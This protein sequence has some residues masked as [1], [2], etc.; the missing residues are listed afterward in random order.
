MLTDKLI[1]QII[2]WQKEAQKECM[3]VISALLQATV[4]FYS[5]KPLED[6]KPAMLHEGAI[7][8]LTEWQK[9]LDI[10][11]YFQQNFSVSESVIADVNKIAYRGEFYQNRAFLFEACTHPSLR[12][13]SP[14]MRQRIHAIELIV[15]HEKTAEALYKLNQVRAT[16]LN[17]SLLKVIFSNLTSRLLSQK[18]ALDSNSD[19]SCNIDLLTAEAVSISFQQGWLRQQWFELVV[20]FDGNIPKSHNLLHSLKRDRNYIDQRVADHQKQRSKASEELIKILNASACKP[21]AVSSK[22]G[23]ASFL[24]QTSPMWNESPQTCRNEIRV[25]KIDKLFL[26]LEQLIINKPKQ[27]INDLELVLKTHESELAY[28]VRAQIDLVEASIELMRPTLNRFRRLNTSAENFKSKLQ[29]AIDKSPHRF[30]DDVLYRNMIG[31]YGSLITLC[32]ELNENL[33]LLQSRTESFNAVASCYSTDDQDI[34]LLV[35]SKLVRCSEQ[36][37]EVSATLSLLS[38][39]AQLRELHS[40]KRSLFY[41]LSGKYHQVDHESTKNTKRVFEEGSNALQRSSHVMRKVENTVADA[42]L[43][44]IKRIKKSDLD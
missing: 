8:L 40:Q 13:I 18:E 14:Q 29:L 35:C 31:S 24:K 28:C 2:N 21:I 7:I 11:F 9:I 33:T 42:Q 5:D 44:E 17:E 38:E 32:D 34:Y 20:L 4:C 26:P 1:Q 41:K 43:R 10:A 16:R 15:C 36:L 23:E 37:S 30:C 25:S 39:C 27:A 12:M 19:L 3:T 22:K 6:D